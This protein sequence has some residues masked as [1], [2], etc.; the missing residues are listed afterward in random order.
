MIAAQGLPSQRV[1]VMASALKRKRMGGRAWF[2]DRRPTLGG[3]PS[4]R[5]ALHWTRS[6]TAPPRG[7]LCRSVL[8]EQFTRDRISAEDVWSLLSRVEVRHCQDFDGPQGRFRTRMRLALHGGDTVEI[9]VDGPLGGPTRPLPNPD[10]VAKA[11]RLAE[12]IDIA[13]RWER[14]E[15]VVLGLDSL[16]DASVLVDDLAASVPTLPVTF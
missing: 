3:R 11:R 15:H 2:F 16:P 5:R 1:T 9:E 10:V 13:E 6:C 4:S 7:A 12:S 14:I 8:A